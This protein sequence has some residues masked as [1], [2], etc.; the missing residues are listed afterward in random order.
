MK[1]N[2]ILISLLGM[3]IFFSSSCNSNKEI[4]TKLGE[5]IKLEESSKEW[6]EINARI[7]ARKVEAIKKEKEADSLL[8]C[9]NEEFFYA[10]P[11]VSDTTELVGKRKQD[12]TELVSYSGYNISGG[13][14]GDTKMTLFNAKGKITVGVQNVTGDLINGYTPWNDYYKL[15]Y[16]K[17][18]KVEDVE[19]I[20]FSGKIGKSKSGTVN[21]N[22]SIKYLDKDSSLTISFFGGPKNYEYKQSGKF[23]FQNPEK[24][25][26][27]IKSIQSNIK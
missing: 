9:C 5:L 2:K 7:R 16:D 18:K 4:E 26:S 14:E 8:K 24:A 17:L 19:G 23:F 6:D 11:S 27:I 13:A 1:N 10:K 21:V 3:V 22:Y 20:G 25:F 12:S 15:E